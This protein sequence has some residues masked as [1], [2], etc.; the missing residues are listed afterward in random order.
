MGSAWRIEDEGALDYIL[1]R[2]NLSKSL[3]WLGLYFSNSRERINTKP[4][5]EK[6]ASIF[7]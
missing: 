5:G 7:F 1:S 2:G 3:Q 6:K 4:A